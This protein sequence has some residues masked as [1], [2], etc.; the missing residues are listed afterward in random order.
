MDTPVVKAYG[1][2]LYKRHSLYPI[3]IMYNLSFKIGTTS[4]LRTQKCLLPCSVVSHY[5]Y[6]TSCRKVKG[7]NA[8]VNVFMQLGIRD[9][10]H[11][12]VKS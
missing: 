8:L 9:T 1:Q 6:N 3:L 2:S 10:S 5:V 11:I 7:V 4:L 12:I